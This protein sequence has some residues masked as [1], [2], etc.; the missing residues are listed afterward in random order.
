MGRRFCLQ[1]GLAYMISASDAPQSF[2]F[3]SAI[4]QLACETFG[5]LLFMTFIE[6]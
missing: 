5:V 2:Y 6:A 3:D 4:L 1:R